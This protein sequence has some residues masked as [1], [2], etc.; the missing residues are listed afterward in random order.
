[1]LTIENLA[2]SVV[3]DSNETSRQILRGIDLEIGPGEVHAIMGPNGSGKSTL[4]NVLTGRDGYEVTGKVLF[5]GADLLSLAPEERA[6]AGLF[7]A[8]QYPVEIPGVGNMYFLRTAVNAVRTNRGEPE[9]S[10]TGVPGHRQVRHGRARDGP[11]VPV[12]VGQ[13]RVLGWREEAQRDTPDDAAPTAHGDPGRDGLG[14]RHRRSAHRGRWHREAAEPRALDAHH[15]PLPTP[16]RV[17]TTRPRT[18]SA[19]VASCVREAPSWHTSSRR[20]ATPT[21]TPP[22]LLRPLVTKMLRPGAPGLRRAP[23]RPRRQPDRIR[24][25]RGRCCERRGRRRAVAPR[26]PARWCRRRGM[27]A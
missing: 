16:A 3:D 24:P 20:W 22:P 2:A 23:H 25:R 17:R 21:T 19:P 27:G 15:H 8:F 10:A 18:C 13:R 1:M 14:P 6:A 9:L 7:L 12:A 4:S 5:D 26:G 11:G